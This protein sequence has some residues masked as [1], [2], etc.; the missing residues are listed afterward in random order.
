MNPKR[1]IYGLSQ[2]FLLITKVPLISLKHKFLDL[3]IGSHIDWH[4]KNGS[5]FMR[6]NNKKNHM[7]HIIIILIIFYLL[8]YAKTQI[9]ILLLSALSNAWSSIWNILYNVTSSRGWVVLIL[10]KKLV[11]KE[12]TDIYLSYI[13]HIWGIFVPNRLCIIVPRRIL[14]ETINYVSTCVMS[15]IHLEKFWSAVHWWCLASN[16]I[17]I[18][19]LYSH[20]VHKLIKLLHYRKP[21]NLKNLSHSLHY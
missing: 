3:I 15:A 7:Y 19:I 5:F 12:K 1:R 16:Y 17:C 14:W 9:L 13:I 11:G 4:V 6:L 20:T 2:N 21:Q 8:S 10:E 18:H